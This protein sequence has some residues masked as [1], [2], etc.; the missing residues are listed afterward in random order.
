PQ[1]RFV[2][3]GQQ[4]LGVRADAALHVLPPVARH[5]PVE[6][7]DVEIVCDVD[8]HRVHDRRRAGRRRHGGAGGR[9]RFLAGPHMHYWPRRRSTVLMVSKMMNTSSAI[10][11]F[12][13]KNRSY[14]SFS[15]AS[16]T[17]AP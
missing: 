13:M 1:P 3:D 14:C 6:D 15:I 16:S 12:L 7:A 2:E 10:D 8:R 4:A 9:R 17:V 11:M 5:Q